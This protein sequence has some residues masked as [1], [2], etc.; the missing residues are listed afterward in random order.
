MKKIGLIAAIAA[1]SF[2]V[3][4]ADPTNYLFY[5][6]GIDASGASTNVTAQGVHR[7]VLVA[8]IDTTETDLT[9]VVSN[10]R[11][12]GELPVVAPDTTAISDWLYTENQVHV[13]GDYLF[14]G[15]AQGVPF[16]VSAK[17][18]PDGTLEESA[19]ET[20]WN[21]SDEIATRH[22]IGATAVVEV[23]GTTYYYLL[24][25][26]GGNPRIDTISYAEVDVE[27][28]TLGS[29]QVATAT[30]PQIDWFNRAVGFNG[31]I[32]HTTG[33]IAR[34]TDGWH[35]DVGVP[36]AVDGDL[37]SFPEVVQA[38]TT[39]QWD[40]FTLVASAGGQDYLVIGGSNTP[41]AAVYTALIDG[42]TVATPATTNPFPGPG[43]RR[44]TGAATGDLVVVPG[45]ST[46]SSSANGVDTVSV[47]RIDSAGVITWGSSTEVMPQPRSFGGAAISG[48]PEAADVSDWIQF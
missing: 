33:N 6:G 42:A 46:A 48:I 23:D 44:I 14:I 47:G 21:F 19:G 26:N 9:A 39:R 13:I 34:T 32:Y 24:G 16:V 1:L 38:F 7:E 2:G 43:L 31:H 8:D 10:W 29:W 45:G 30:L 41:S 5:V 40:N 35:V 15:R 27:N 36:S 11:V 12:A 20:V 3:A 4:N 18:Q 22:D 25:G 37:A 17:I 28:G